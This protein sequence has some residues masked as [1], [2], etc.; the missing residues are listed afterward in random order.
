MR[1]KPGHL[2]SVELAIL[3]TAVGLRANGAQEFHGFMIAKEMVDRRHSRRLTWH[4]TLYKALDRFRQMG[5]LVDRW[6]DPMV[7][8]EDGRPRRRLYRVTVA[9]QQALVDAD[10]RSAG[11]LPDAKRGMARP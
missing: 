3:R 2:L 5:F 6:E 11:A 8:A 1:R 9:G 4:G 7:A 10:A